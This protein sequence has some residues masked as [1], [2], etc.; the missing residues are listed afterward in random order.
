M[1]CFSPITPGPQS[2]CHLQLVIEET[3]PQ[4]VTSVAWPCSWSVE[5]L[6]LNLG[7]WAAKD[8]KP[9]KNPSLAAWVHWPSSTWFPGPLSLWLQPWGMEPPPQVHVCDIPKGGRGHSTWALHLSLLWEQKDR[10][11]VGLAWMPPP[12]LGLS[13]LSGSKEPGCFLWGA[14]LS[15]GMVVARFNARALPG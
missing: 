11:G 14:V 2:N 6:A 13:S 8:K 4:K 9:Q 3:E 10:A 7:S 5:K 15:P 12:S 1:G